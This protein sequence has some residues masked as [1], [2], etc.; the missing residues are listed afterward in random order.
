MFSRK[1][2]ISIKYVD[3]HTDNGMFTVLKSYSIN[4]QKGKNF[5]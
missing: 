5:G 3:T 4:I 2:Y 1:A